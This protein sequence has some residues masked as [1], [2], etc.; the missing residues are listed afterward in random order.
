MAV[1]AFST[2]GFIN[3]NAAEASKSDAPIIFKEM[4]KNEFTV[5]YIAIIKS[6]D[7]NNDGALS[8]EE[9]LQYRAAPL[10]K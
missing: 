8:E 1:I 2:M 4:D 3:L 10:T 9:Y 5:M 7:K 6:G